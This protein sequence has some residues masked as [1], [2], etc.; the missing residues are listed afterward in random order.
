[1]NAPDAILQRV[2]SGPQGT[3]G[4]FQAGRFHAYSLELPW[5]DNR[6]NVSAIPAGTYLCGFTHS[7][8]FGRCLYLLGSVPGRSGV[9]IHP[10]NLARQLNGCIALG[11]RLG[12]ID[13][14]KAVL[15]SA[16]AVRRLEELKQGR[17][18]T[19]EVDD[20]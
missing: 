10:A 15:V 4:R 13:G 3:F 18:F 16:P 14:V 20:V 9:R 19:L 8:R 12:W 11:E 5:R 1:M 7:P 17:A 2:E 6:P